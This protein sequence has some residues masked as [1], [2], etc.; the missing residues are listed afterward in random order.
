MSALRQSMLR[1]M[2]FNG[3]ADLVSGRG[4]FV[5][6][7]EAAAEVSVETACADGGGASLLAGL[8]QATAN[9]ANVSPDFVPG[10]S[11]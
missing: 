5:A 8:L 9:A 6:A 11:C 3:P 2:T 1:I 4:A 10:S 7:E